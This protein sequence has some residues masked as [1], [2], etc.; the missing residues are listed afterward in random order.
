MRKIFII[1]TVMLILISCDEVEEVGMTEYSFI[2]ESGCDIQ[3]DAY[4]DGDVVNAYYLLNDFTTII[5]FSREESPREGVLPPPFNTPVDSCIVSYCDVYKLRHLE[6]YSGVPE[7]QIP[8]FSLYDNRNY[9]LERKDN[10]LLYSF[11]FTDLDLRIAMNNS[12][13]TQ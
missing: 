13:N 10:D 7:S 4:L 5:S 8:I 2:N 9:E 11:R 6:D 1:F 12:Q 3:I